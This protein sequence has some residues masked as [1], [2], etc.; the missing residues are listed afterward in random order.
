MSFSDRLAEA[1]RARGVDPSSRSQDGYG[2]PHAPTANAA[3]SAT[4]AR[5]SICFNDGLTF[6]HAGA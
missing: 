1:R 5:L 4:R 2:A 6:R 3:T